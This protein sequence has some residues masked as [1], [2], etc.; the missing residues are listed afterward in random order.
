M[1][2]AAVILL[3]KGHQL[4]IADLGE[5]NIPAVGASD[6]DLVKLGDGF[7]LRDEALTADDHDVA[8][9]QLLNVLVLEEIVVVNRECER[10]I[11]FVELTDRRVEGH[12]GQIVII[13]IVR[14]DYVRQGGR[15]RQGQRRGHEQGCQ[16]L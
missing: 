10:L 14:G 15:R 5:D 11:D 8:L 16:F 4:L 13:R 3:V 7:F 2:E 12:A 1:H 6:R 9:L